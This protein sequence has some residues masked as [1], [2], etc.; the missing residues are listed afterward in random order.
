MC[1]TR[2]SQ[3][4]EGA[5]IQPY[6]EREVECRGPSGARKEI[7]RD[8]EKYTLKRVY[9]NTMTENNNERWPRLVTEYERRCC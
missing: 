5:V 6:E 7:S 4:S 3:S 8:K 2:K 1:K 9:Y